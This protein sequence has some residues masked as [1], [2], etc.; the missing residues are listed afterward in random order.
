MK[1]ALMWYTYLLCVY[2]W[3]R[4][5]NERNANSRVKPLPSQFTTAFTTDIQQTFIVNMTANMSF[6]R[7][8][9]LLSG[10]TR[11]PNEQITNNLHVFFAF[12]FVAFS[13][14]LRDVSDF[15]RKT[16][17]SFSAAAYNAAE[18]RSGV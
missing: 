18:D 10:G 3:L 14:C 7:S 12:F 15:L 13:S 4:T 11:E 6:V 1:A 17:S 5:K 9:V 16:L 2:V 8:R